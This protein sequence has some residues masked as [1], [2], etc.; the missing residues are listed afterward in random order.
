MVFALFNMRAYEADNLKTLCYG[1]VGAYMIAG[2]VAVW[3]LVTANHLENIFMEQAKLHNIPGFMT[4]SFFSNPNNYGA[5]ILL[6]APFIWCAWRSA[7]GK[8]AQIFF[9]A[10]MITIPFFLTTSGSRIAIAGVVAQA[11]VTLLMQKR[12]KI[13]GIALLALAIMV[14]IASIYIV[15][16]QKG[17]NAIKYYQFADKVLEDP[18]FV[19]RIDL[20]VT[21]L[22]MLRDSWGM[23]CGAG[24]FESVAQSSRYSHLLSG[25][26]VS[27][28]F[29]IEV[30]SEYGIIIFGFFI[31]WF[32]GLFYEAHLA[33]QRLTD[34]V[35][36][37]E[38]IFPKVLIIALTGYLFASL[39]HSSY[40][41]ET[42]NWT[43]LGTVNVIGAHLYDLRCKES[44]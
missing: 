34:N 44:T 1:W 35:T 29:L 21:G 27:H 30:L 23:G 22:L 5:F 17:M 38:N 26:Y 9:L 40:M 36:L 13:K 20:S 24:S 14:L 12:N 3:E 15:A 43:F 28:N 2:G 31:Y 11:L 32:I 18:S 19:T 41:Q 6:S 39:C 10:L 37:P 25:L 8:V 33:Q 42:T 7:K 4:I 16:E